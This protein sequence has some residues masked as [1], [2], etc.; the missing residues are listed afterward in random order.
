MRRGSRARADRRT[1]VRFLSASR[2]MRSNGGSS[3]GGAAIASIASSTMI[4]TRSAEVPASYDAA[5]WRRA[6]AA[7][8]SSR[9]NAMSRPPAS[10]PSAIHSVAY[11]VNEPISRT[12]RAPAT[13]AW[14]NRPC[15]APLTMCA[16]LRKARRR[17]RGSPWPP[18]GAA[19]PLGRGHDVAVVDGG[20]RAARRTPAPRRGA[21]NCAQ[22]HGGCGGA[23][24]SPAAGGFHA[25]SASDPRGVLP[26]VA[27]AAAAA[28]GRSSRRRRGRNCSRQRAPKRAGTTTM[29]ALDR[30]PSGGVL[31]DGAAG[32]RRVARRL[33]ESGA[34]PADPCAPPCGCVQ[35]PTCAGGCGAASR[36]DGAAPA[37]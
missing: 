29:P 35:M 27:G 19:A 10:I 12:R 6:T 14:S 37:C 22:E 18:L 3:A 20:W 23:R 1:P 11:P 17:R 34:V 16:P 13:S 2:K 30:S 28:C 24:G 32:P 15:C 26:V 33:C 21:R 25:T 8:R 7:A 5:R 31:R 4:S 9:S 36:A